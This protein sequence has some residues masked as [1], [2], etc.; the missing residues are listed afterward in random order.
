MAQKRKAVLLSNDKE[1]QRY[2]VQRGVRY[3]TIADVLRLLWLEQILSPDEVR[4]AMAL[5]KHVETHSFTA[6][7]LTEIFAPVETET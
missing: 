6:N 2:C 7:Q 3:F 5:M 1:A 4:A